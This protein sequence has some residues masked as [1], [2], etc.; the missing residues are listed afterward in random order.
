MEGMVKDPRA[1]GPGKCK[2]QTV[3]KCEMLLVLCCV[4]DESF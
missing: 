1:E 4:R 3:P 2:G